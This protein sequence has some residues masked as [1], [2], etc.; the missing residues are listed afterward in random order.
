METK[1]NVLLKQD[2]NGFTQWELDIA[3][4][5]IKEQIELR[6]KDFMRQFHAGQPVAVTTNIRGENGGYAIYPAY[7]VKVNKKSMDIGYATY[8]DYSE[9][10]HL[11]QTK[12]V[13]IQSLKSNVSNGYLCNA[14]PSKFEGGPQFRPY[15][16]TGYGC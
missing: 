3:A 6:D 7:I 12:R 8:D 4:N 2:F 11:T 15:S 1:S 9:K 13:T 14:Y 10:S 16:D 5:S